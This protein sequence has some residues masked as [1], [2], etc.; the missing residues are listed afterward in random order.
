MSLSAQEADTSL[1]LCSV[2]CACFQ[3]PPWPAT[4]SHLLCPLVCPGPRDVR[5][6][7]WLSQCHWDSFA[8]PGEGNASLLLLPQALGLHFNASNWPHLGYIVLVEARVSAVWNTVTSRAWM[9]LQGR[10]QC[11]YQKKG[12]WTLAGCRIHGTAGLKQRCAQWEL[13]STHQ[14]HSFFY[15]FLGS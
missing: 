4:W 14:N 10:V 7:W 6:L 5:P 12:E 11:S 9:V 8:A 1:R 2:R 3:G 15:E 13:A